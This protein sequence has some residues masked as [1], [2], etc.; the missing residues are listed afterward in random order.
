MNK[1]TEVHALQQAVCKLM[2]ILDSLFE[3][4][5]QGWSRN[6]SGLKLE[7]G[8]IQRPENA[9]V[10]IHPVGWPKN[11]YVSAR[12]D[13]TDNEGW[14]FWEGYIYGYHIQLPENPEGFLVSFAI[15]N[16][17]Y[18]RKFEFDIID[19]GTPSAI[20]FRKLAEQAGMLYKRR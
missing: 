10:H 17:G 8:I 15:P 16:F 2:F 14:S 12:F 19:V 18:P 5:L 11:S 1:K 4:Q 13:G 20:V 9:F 7:P 6:V 3:G